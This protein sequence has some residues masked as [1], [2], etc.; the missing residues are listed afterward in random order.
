MG[1]S[2][3]VM[4]DWLIAK[5][6]KLTSPSSR[7]LASEFT[8][9]I[10]QFVT[11]SLGTFFFFFSSRRRHTRS[12]CD[13]SSDV[14]SSDL[15]GLHLSRNPEGI[16]Q[17]AAADRLV[18]T[19]SDLAAPGQTDIVCNELARLNPSARIWDAAQEPVDA[20]FLLDG[21]PFAPAPGR[22]RYRL[23]DGSASAR[24]ERP[25]RANGVGTH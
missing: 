13:W 11:C 7:T 9:R 17:V 2:S 23:E 20:D 19:K 21:L 18:L 25:G 4:G 14:C 12:L 6:H 22:A 1:L 24:G 16:K 15:A 10:S 8:A 3:P 5:W